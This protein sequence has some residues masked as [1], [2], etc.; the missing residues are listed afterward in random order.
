[1]QKALIIGGSAGSFQ[2]VIKILSSLPPNFNLPVLLCMHRLKHVRTG[3]VE[4]LS[5]K[6]KLPVSEP[7]DKEPIKPGHAYLAPA[8]YHMYI[9]VNH[10]IFLS[11]E[12]AV[13]HSRPSI[14]LSFFS[15]AQCYQDHLTGILLS[16]ANRDGAAG[17]KSV[18][19]H[20]GTTIVQDPKEAEVPVMP[21]AALSLFNPTHIMATA[22]IIDY[23]KSII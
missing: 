2:E 20:K 11:A 8:N 6:S 23:L 22:Q 1:M 16:G 19:D 13:H 4:A 18:A 10:K 15:A 12:E 17:L 14:D 5:L 21:Q 3:F 7:F 9:D